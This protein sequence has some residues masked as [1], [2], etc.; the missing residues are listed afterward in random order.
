MPTAQIIQ[1]D[2]SDAFNMSQIRTIYSLVCSPA[3]NHGLHVLLSK[4]YYLKTSQTT[5][6]EK[7]IFSNNRRCSI[8]EVEIYA[9]NKHNK[10]TYYRPNLDNPKG[11]L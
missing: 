3:I 10:W 9:I 4:I 1:V 6:T 8:D 2:N 7:N 5:G 11:K